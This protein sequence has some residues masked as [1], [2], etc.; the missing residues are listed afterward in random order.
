MNS[1]YI[2]KVSSQIRL[3]IFRNAKISLC[4]IR[5]HMV[6]RTLIYRLGAVASGAIVVYSWLFVEAYIDTE[7]KK[8]AVLFITWQSLITRMEHRDNSVMVSFESGKT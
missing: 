5:T 2:L 4:T 1:Q 8:F 7:L 3:R 6:L